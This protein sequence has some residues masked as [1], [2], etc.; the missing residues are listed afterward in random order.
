MA[1]A[2]MLLVFRYVNDFSRLK[3]VEVGNT[4]IQPGTISKIVFTNNQSSKVEFMLRCHFKVRSDGK[5]LFA[6]A[7]SLPPNGSVEFDVNPDLADRELPRMIANKACEAIW[8]GPFG[9]KRSA[10]WVSWEFGRPARKV[11]FE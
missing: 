11:T 7:I 4:P 6:E 5:A 8:Q 10:W 3:R 9:I 2:A 1:L